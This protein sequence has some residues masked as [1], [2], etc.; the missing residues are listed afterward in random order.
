MLAMAVGR[1]SGPSLRTGNKD[2]KRASESHLARELL[3]FINFIGTNR[4]R[5]SVRRVDNT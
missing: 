5:D 4:R 3:L 1:A 2:K